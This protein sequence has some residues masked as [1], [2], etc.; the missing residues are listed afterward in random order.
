MKSTVEAMIAEER[1]KRH[2][3]YADRLSKALSASLAAP[4]SAASFASSS[5]SIASGR[6]F[7]LESQPRRTLNDLVLDASV[8]QQVE[9]LV[10]EHHRGDL[11][12]SYGVQPRHRILLAGPP[13][14]G[15]TSLAEAIAEALSVPFFVV[16]YDA[17]IGS[18]L[19]ETNQRLKRL[20][21]Y[22]RT[23]PC[24]ILFDEFDALGKERGDVHETGEIKR[25]VSSL[26]LQID[27]LP[28]YVVL[29]AATNHEELL[30]R[31]AWRRFEM[32]LSMAKP[33]QPMVLDYVKNALATEGVLSRDAVA[34]VAKLALSSFAEAGDFVREIRRRLILADAG[35]SLND[36]IRERSRVWASRMRVPGDGERS[37]EATTDVRSATDGGKKKGSASV[38]SSSSTGSA[39][40]SGRSSRP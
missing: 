13:G 39:S 8:R 28:T 33:S 5:P 11:L 7:I 14:N 2:D 10:T 24:V 6:D 38:R 32:R 31:A 26:L 29:I 21:D 37:V 22:V 3:V 36:A 40:K 20:F 30:D 1:S 15:K 25:V 9:E 18:Y 17:L 34:A 23:T 27:A 4:A 16:R 12:R 19:G 35:I